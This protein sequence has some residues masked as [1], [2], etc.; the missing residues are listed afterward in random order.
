MRDSGPALAGVAAYLSAA[1]VD[2]GRGSRC[3]QVRASVVSHDFLHVLGIRPAL[4][5]LF[6]AAD[7][8]VPGA[9]P[10]AVVS[11]AMWQSRFAGAADALGKTLLVNGVQLEI[12]G[13]TQKSF[14][15]I[16]AEGVDLWL[17]S[18]M[19]GPLGLLSADGDWR[20]VVVSL[21]AMWPAWRRGLRN[22]LPRARRRKRCDCAP[23]TRISI[24]RRKY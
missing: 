15:G 24:R 17:P 5:R 14:A 7:D 16:E 11:H 3:E 22:R 1:L 18:S 13:V 9:H 20:T 19:A 23:R 21:R 8:G 10:V 4:G 6:V 12:I 2:V